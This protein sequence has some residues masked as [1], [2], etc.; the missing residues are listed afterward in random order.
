MGVVVIIQVWFFFPVDIGWGVGWGLVGRSQNLE[1][2]LRPFGE[3]RSPLS[4]LLAH[5][6]GIFFVLPHPSSISSST[7]LPS[8]SSL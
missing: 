6:G 7:T 2:L 8:T 5:L 3:S 4:L 1:F